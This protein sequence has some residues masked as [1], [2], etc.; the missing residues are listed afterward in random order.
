M[1]KASSDDLARAI[2]SRAS[3]AKV[4]MSSG[5]MSD[6]PASRPSLSA[7]RRDQSTMKS[8]SVA[9]GRDESE[10]AA[11]SSAPDS[12]GSRAP[13]R[14]LAWS[15]AA[16]AQCVRFWSGDARRLARPEG[17]EPPAYRFEAC[18]S[19]QLSYGRVRFRL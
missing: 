4:S 10:S 18:R 9:N 12:A 2:R 8:E 17:L 11:R 6:S 3:T 1:F 14:F 7:S 15:C 16:G 5:T 13:A 19:I